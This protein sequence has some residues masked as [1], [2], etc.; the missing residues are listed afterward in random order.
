MTSNSKDNKS[1]Y[2]LFIIMMMPVINTDLLVDCLSS[3]VNGN[4]NYT[5][6][7]TQLYNNN[8]F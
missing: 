3:A 6:I 1:D 2:E 8:S 4:L 5:K 7:Y